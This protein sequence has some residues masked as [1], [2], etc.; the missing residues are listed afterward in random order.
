MTPKSIEPIGRKYND[1][2]I[3]RVKVSPAEEKKKLRSTFIWY[4]IMG[5]VNSKDAM[6]SDTETH[7]AVTERF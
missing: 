7:A 4:I 2:N 1:D 6:V 5:T 3:V